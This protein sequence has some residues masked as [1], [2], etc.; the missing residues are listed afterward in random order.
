MLATG[1]PALLAFTRQAPG[2]TVLVV[3][4]LSGATAQSGDL[5]VAG[6]TATP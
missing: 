4:N 6:T 1:S 5:S 3:H 2:E